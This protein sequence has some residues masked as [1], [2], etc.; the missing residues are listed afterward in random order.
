MVIIIL[1]SLAFRTGKRLDRE[2]NFTGIKLTYHRI[3]SQ[4]IEISNH[5]AIH[6]K[7]I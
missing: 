1:S 7:L 4:V 6:M 2:I 5:Y 3:T